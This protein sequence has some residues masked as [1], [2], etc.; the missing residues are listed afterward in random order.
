M[1]KAN[2]DCRIC[3]VEPGATNTETFR[4]FMFYG[5]R[6]ICGKDSAIPNFDGMSNEELNCLLDNID[7]LLMIWRR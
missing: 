3:D 5:I 4:E 7:Y 6:S 1:I 2:L